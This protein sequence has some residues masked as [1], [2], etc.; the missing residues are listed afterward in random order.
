MPLVTRAKVADCVGPPGL[1]PAPRRRL[2]ELEGRLLLQAAVHVLHVLRAGA[3]EVHG[4]SGG[5]VRRVEE[6]VPVRWGPKMMELPAGPSASVTLMCFCRHRPLS[7]YV[8]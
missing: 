8:Q 1:V 5:V 7:S 6:L 2:D 3:S 4:E